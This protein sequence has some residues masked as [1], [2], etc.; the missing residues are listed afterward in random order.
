GHTYEQILQ[1][2]YPGAELKSFT[3]SA[4]KN[5][6]K[7][8]PLP[9]GEYVEAVT[10]FEVNFRTEP[11]TDCE[12]ITLLKKGTLVKVYSRNNGWAFAVYNN[13]AGYLYDAYLSYDPT[14]SQSPEATAAPTPTQTP[15]PKPTQ[16][17]SPTIS[18]TGSPTIP[19]VVSPTPTPDMSNVKF[20]FAKGITNSE[21]N[22]RTKPTTSGSVVIQK[23]A[24]S[25]EVNILGFC[26]DWYYVLYNNRTGFVSSQYVKV[27]S[28]GSMGIKE[29][30]PTLTLIATSTTAIVN[31]RHAPST[32]APL[33]RKLAMGDKLTVYLVQD[34]WCLVKQGDEYGYVYAD[35]VRLA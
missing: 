20:E 5:P 25:T 26:G 9:T 34:G 15:T 32:N 11:N 23:L 19:P 12:I 18:L 14:A 27:T 29:V 31:M 13:T 3:V 8:L 22:F 6:I 7:P 28:Q 24:A 4:P 35:Y 10:A 16:S 33:I 2:Y 30:P 21:V 1:F 17:A